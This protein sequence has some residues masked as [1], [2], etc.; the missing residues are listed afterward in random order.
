MSALDGGD[1]KTMWLTS[2]W[3]RLNWRSMLSAS[4]MLANPHTGSMKARTLKVF[5]GLPFSSQETVSQG[6]GTER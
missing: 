4:R 3:K 6:T 1:D 5:V 2:F